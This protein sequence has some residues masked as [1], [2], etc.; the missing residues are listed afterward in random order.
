MSQKISYILRRSKKSKRVRLQVHSDGRI[1]VTSPF[2]IR[3]SMVE[4]FI[5]DKIKWIESKIN[6]FNG[7]KNGVGLTFSRNDYKKHKKR[8]SIFLSER[9]NFYNKF[10]KF[11]FNKICIK[12]QKTRWGSCS[13][14]GNINLNYKILFLPKELQDYIIVHEI[15]HLKEMNHKDRFW[16]LVSQTFPNHIEIRKK[17][18]Q[19][20][21]LLYN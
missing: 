7:I 3:R 9:V 14:K 10:Y 4:N 1:V 5:S 16:A 2:R 6:Y 18:R 15:C 17:L 13:R 11:S 19:P 20:E 12:N 8:A 21:F